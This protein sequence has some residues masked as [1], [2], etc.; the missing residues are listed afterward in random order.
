LTA[1]KDLSDGVGTSL[2][3]AGAAKAAGGQLQRRRLFL[4]AVFPPA[5]YINGPDEYHTLVGY[6]PLRDIAI[7]CFT[8]LE[9]IA[10]QVPFDIFRVG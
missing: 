5:H 6:L 9:T 7:R 2:A 10:Q 8:C 4:L 1:Q 3:V